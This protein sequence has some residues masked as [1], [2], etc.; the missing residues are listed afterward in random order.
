MPMKKRP[1]SPQ[2]TV[3]YMEACPPFLKID[4][5]SDFGKEVLQAF[6]ELKPIKVPFSLELFYAVSIV[7][8]PS[9]RKIEVEFR[10]A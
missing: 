8:V 10:R 3:S 5:D 1:K 6:L 7:G 2:F 4:P 9:E